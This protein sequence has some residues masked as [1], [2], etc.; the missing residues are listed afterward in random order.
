VHLL[1]IQTE[2][3][4]FQPISTEK[5]EN[6]YS[7]IVQRFTEINRFF[8]GFKKRHFW[9]SESALLQ[10]AMQNE[11]HFAKNAEEPF[12]WFPNLAWVPDFFV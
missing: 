11:K 12:F 2:F 4:P 3:Q 8:S 9:E 5:F 1:D 7:H 10:N 6:F